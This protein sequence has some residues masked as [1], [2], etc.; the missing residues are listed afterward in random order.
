VKKINIHGVELCGLGLVGALEA[1]Q[2]SIEYEVDR[3]RT[4]AVRPNLGLMRYLSLSRG[5]KCI[6]AMKVLSGVLGS[7][8][9]AQMVRECHDRGVWIDCFVSPNGKLD[10]FVTDEPVK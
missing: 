5:V 2:A 4:P 6:G 1:I 8:I 9:P 3:G 7:Q 10:W